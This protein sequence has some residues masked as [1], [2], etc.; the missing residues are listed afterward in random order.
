MLM[1]SGLP[2]SC[3]LQVRALDSDLPLALVSTR[4]EII[5]GDGVVTGPGFE[6]HHDSYE[7]LLE[8]AASA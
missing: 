4:F 1:T 5:D 2:T 3:M 6:G 7:S 8:D